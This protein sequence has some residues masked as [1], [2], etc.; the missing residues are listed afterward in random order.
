MCSGNGDILSYED[1]N[2]CIEGSG[3]SG[4]MIA[5]LG[6]SYLIMIA[7]LSSSYLIMIARLGSSY[8][9]MI[10]RFYVEEL[11]FKLLNSHFIIISGKARFNLLCVIGKP[12][13]TFVVMDRQN[14]S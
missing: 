12:H 7:R 1:Y 11:T 9:I 2:R 5:R 8:L 10:A 13:P 14:F 6:S 3:V 4:C